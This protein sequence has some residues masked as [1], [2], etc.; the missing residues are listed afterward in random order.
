MPDDARM[1]ELESRLRDLGYYDGPVESEPWPQ[2]LL[3][4]RRFQRNQGLPESGRVD[5]ATERA[6][7]EAY[8][9]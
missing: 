6:L 5:P 8:C 7:R 3:A 4:L 9:Y 2:T 1:R